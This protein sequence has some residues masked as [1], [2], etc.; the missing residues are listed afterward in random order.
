M[1]QIAPGSHLACGDVDRH[2]CVGLDGEWKLCPTYTDPHATLGTLQLIEHLPI[3]TY[4]GCHWPVKRGKEIWEFCTE[5]REFVQ[6]AERL[7]LA[8]LET[9]KSLRELCLEQGPLLGDWPR[10][11]DIDLSFSLSGHLSSLKSRGLITGRW[12]EIAV[13]VTEYFRAHEMGI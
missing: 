5:T 12:R 7:L 13:P 11:A 10:S 4:V 9:P 6:K 1:K 2:I 8:S 3:T